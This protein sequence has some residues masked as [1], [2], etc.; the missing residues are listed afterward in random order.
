M[1]RIFEIRKC[2]KLY[3]WTSAMLPLSLS[4][5]SIGLDLS[6]HSLIVLRFW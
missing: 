4:Q 3:V 5:C 6:V 2:L 1:S